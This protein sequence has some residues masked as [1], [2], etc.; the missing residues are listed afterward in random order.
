MFCS[1]KVKD[2]L[3]FFV[4]MECFVPKKLKIPYVFSLK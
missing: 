1:K 3:C 2:S 4:E